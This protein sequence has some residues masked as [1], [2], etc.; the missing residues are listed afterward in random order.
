MAMRTL[1]FGLKPLISRWRPRDSTAGV[2]SG[3]DDVQTR[4]CQVVLVQ[5]LLSS[6]SSLSLTS[7]KFSLGY[8]CSL[9]LIQTQS[10]CFSQSDIPDVYIKKNLQLGMSCSML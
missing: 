8:S 6:L 2:M 9:S 1:I 5:V 4:V 7:A 10:Q 3:R